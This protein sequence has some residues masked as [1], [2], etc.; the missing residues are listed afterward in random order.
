MTTETTT[1][2]IIANSLDMGTWEATS[3]D[4]AIDAYLADA[5]YDSREAAAKA[6]GQSIEEMLADIEVTEA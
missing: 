5:G 4:A 1:Y 6:L 3:A 2:T